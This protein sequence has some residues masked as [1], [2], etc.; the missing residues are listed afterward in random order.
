MGT[1][2]PA[3]GPGRAA[4][5]GDATEREAERALGA[6]VAAR[7]DG[8]DVEPSRLTLGAY[9]VDRW[10]PAAATTVRQTTMNGG[11]RHVVLSVVPRIRALPL[12]AVSPGRL[13]VL[14]RP[15]LE[16]GGQGG[17]PLSPT[18]GAV[19]G[20]APAGVEQKRGRRLAAVRP[21]RL[22]AAWH[23]AVSTG[24]RRGDPLAAVCDC[25]AQRIR[26][27]ER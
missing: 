25:T 21:D 2:C 1:R 20:G 8:S 23:L 19:G 24:M 16:R 9:L 15:L 22:H 10:L 26:P 11:R 18:S 3:S 17:R 13:S 14:D 7:Y 5:S 6:L 12:Q 4:G 27:L